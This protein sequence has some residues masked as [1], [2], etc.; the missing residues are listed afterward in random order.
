M[1][2][3]IP[4]AIKKT[5]KIIDAWLPLKI[6][7][8]NTPGLSVGIT[9]KGKL[10]YKRGFGYADQEA[11]ISATP[12]TCY[13]IASIS[14]TFTSIS[15]FQLAEKGRLRIDD[16][17]EKYLPWFKAKRDNKNADSITIRQL[18]SHTAGVFRDGNSPHWEN[19]KF[20][21][22]EKMQKSIVEEMLVFKN[23]AKF[24]YSNFGFAI[25]G[26]V[27]EAVSGMPY[28]QYMRVNILDKLGM[29]NTA[30]DFDVKFEKKLAKGYSRDVPGERKKIFKNTRTNAYASAAGVLSNVEDLAKY[31]SAWFSH[32]NG[33]VSGRSKKEM[34]REYS[35]ARGKDEFY[36]LGFDVYKI[37]KRKIAGHGGG[38]PGFVTKIGLDVKNDIGVIVLANTNDSTAGFI[39]AGI[40]ESIYKFLD[41]KNYSVGSVPKNA[42]KYE[43]IYRSRW[44]DA[45]VVGV[46][47]VLVVFD[48]KTNSPL[49]EE[50]Y[51]VPAGKDKFVIKT[52]FNFDAPGEFARFITKGG[53]KKASVLF[54]GSTPHKRVK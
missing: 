24:K 23:P 39:H 4:E 41:D 53:G 13:R 2:K 44:D 11:K 17:V 43:G 54:W 9:Y 33:L 42:K 26:K 5:S 16:K 49:E 52:K 6:K 30:S 14:K 10:V 35:R 25:L 15:I 3:N 31:I 7:Y 40:F 46:G 36:G 48:S 29:K 47:G 37:K 22:L 32:K 20:P 12:K 1:N 19:D 50:T 51:L 28:E 34:T 27:I 18:L 45:V 38:F 21:D 8:D